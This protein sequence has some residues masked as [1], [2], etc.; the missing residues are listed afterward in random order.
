MLFCCPKCGLALEEKGNV[1]SCKNGHS[2]D[3]A[4]GGYYNLLLSN[5][6]GVHGDNKDMV[7]ARRAFLGAGYYAPLAER[8]ASL[9]AEY[10]SSGSV[11]LDAGCGEGYYTDKVES[12]VRAKY[13]ESRVCAFDISKDAVRE[14][15]RKNS[16]IELA[17][18]GSYS[19][20]LP[21]GSVDAVINTFSPLALSEVARVLSSH[22]TF[23]IVIP[24]EEHLYELKSAI[25]DTPY[26]NTVS[27]TALDGF[28]LFLDEKLSFRMHLPSPEAVGALFKMTPY[29]YRTSPENVKKVE[30]LES[31]VCTADFRI[32]VYRKQ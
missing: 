11:L 1:T 27:D 26:K 16:F 24:G 2:F 8:V 7:L 6:G 18:A 25:Y 31:L 14:A 15:R 22:G 23:I 5:K 30:A 20:P 32:L 12:A 29:A 17:V 28:S 13:G 9:A 19:M 4:K 3:R 21:D 10:T